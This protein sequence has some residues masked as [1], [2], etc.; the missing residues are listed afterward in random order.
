MIEL[1]LF[2]LSVLLV[3]VWHNTGL[4]SKRPKAYSAIKQPARPNEGPVRESRYVHEGFTGHPTIQTLHDIT[5]NA[6]K[7]YPGE[8]CAGSRKL[9]KLIT[10]EKEVNGQKRPWTYYQLST[11]TWTSFGDYIQRV[12]HF[13]AG[14]MHI[15][16]KPKQK[17]AIFEETRME[18]TIAAQA[19]F[20]QSMSV[21][22][23]YANLG[24]EAWS[25]LSTSVKL[26]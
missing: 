13:A 26:K 18:W 11:Y 20:R 7:N 12:I 22:T 5:T 14:L 6:A 9:E 1:I 17:L 2:L 23:V 10:E 15:G 21:L 3:L 24:E 4:H 25:T 8:I 16:M 19:A